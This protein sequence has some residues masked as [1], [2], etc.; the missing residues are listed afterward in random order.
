[1]QR[2]GSDRDVADLVHLLSGG[3]HAADLGGDLEELH[4]RQAAGVAGESTLGTAS[5]FDVPRAAK[6]ALLRGANHRV[7]LLD[8]RLVPAVGTDAAN[9]TLGGYADQSR[10]DAE[11]LDANVFQSRDGAYRIVGVESREHQVARHRRLERDG[12][13]FSISNLTDEQNV[14]VLAEHGPQHSG[15]RQALF[16]IHLDLVD[17]AQPI[18]DRVFDGYDVDRLSAPEIE[19]R[20]E[21]RRLSRSGRSGDEKDALLTHQKGL[22]SLEHLGHEAQR[23]HRDLH[24]LLVEESHDDFLTDA[25]REHRHAERDLFAGHANLGAPILRAEALGDVEVG[26]DLDA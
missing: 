26:H 19:R 16:L 3:D 24:R 10:R 13:R 5:S 25:G 15:E 20:V 21:R 8:R 9:E 6:L 23:L 4:E 11:R 22:E 1:M 18:L 12:R 2:T 7:Q 14:G 17:A